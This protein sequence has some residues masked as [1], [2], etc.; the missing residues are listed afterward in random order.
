MGCH[1]LLRNMPLS[2]VQLSCSVVSDSL[3]PHESQHA[4]PPCPSPTPGVYS[5]SGPSSQRSYPAISY[6]S[7][8]SQ[9]LHCILSLLKGTALEHLYH[10]PR[11]LPEN[12]C[13]CR[14]TLRTQNID[15]PLTGYLTT[16]WAVFIFF[17]CLIRKTKYILVKLYDIFLHYVRK[18]PL[19][20]R[21]QLLN[22]LSLLISVLGVPSWLRW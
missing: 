16:F 14:Q 19:K 20:L 10:L 11:V 4:R 5:D 1:C 2:S 7:G 18:I 6:A 22:N 15:G 8:H 21:S 3:R 12:L 9:M 13:S 17:T